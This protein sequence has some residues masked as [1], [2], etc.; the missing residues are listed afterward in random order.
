MEKIFKLAILC[1]MLCL[2]AR[3]SEPPLGSDPPPLSEPHLSSQSVPV[4][5]S[6]L[7]N[8]PTPPLVARPWTSSVILDEWTNMFAQLQE[9]DK[10]KLLHKIV[11]NNLFA[12]QVIGHM[13]FPEIRAQLGADSFASGEDPRRWL[14]KIFLARMAAIELQVHSISQE[15]ILVL[16]PPLIR[17]T[18]EEYMRVNQS[19]YR[20][21][22]ANISG[23]SFSGMQQSLQ[24]FLYESLAT[25]LLSGVRI[26]EPCYID[27]LS[28]EELNSNIVANSFSLFVRREYLKEL[29]GN[30][31]R[32][33]STK[34]A[35]PVDRM[36]DDEV[37]AFFND[38]L[39][40]DPHALLSDTGRRN[41]LK[42]LLFHPRKHPH[43][44]KATRIPAISYRLRIP[45][46]TA[47]LQI[48]EVVG[49]MS[50]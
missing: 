5:A 12:N 43:E 21:D 19:E 49:R 32:F 24:K 16:F 3:A 33:V 44:E 22:F 6:L 25:D 45:M 20:Q 8:S 2:D 50:K 38:F 27:S 39:H 14:K 17:Q 23:F 42:T 30:A 46:N 1:V 13:T 34:G 7:F 11:A 40:R 31:T 9:N 48:R 10:A 28:E 35:S 41:Y 29:F 15:E 37:A 47:A 26:A 36:S 4:V 18:L